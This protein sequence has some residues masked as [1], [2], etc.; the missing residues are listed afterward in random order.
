MGYPASIS[1]IIRVTRFSFFY[2]YPATGTWLF[3]VSGTKIIQTFVPVKNTFPMVLFLFK[4]LL[5]SSLAPLMSLT[6]APATGA[7]PPA[8]AQAKT[9]VI[10]ERHPFYISVTEINYNGKEKNLEISCKVF[11]EDIEQVL[12]K[13]Y[14]TELD[15]SKEA[16]KKSFDKYLP[17][18]ISRHLALTIDGKPVKLNYIGFEKEKESAF[19]YLEVP[20]A[21]P[22]KKIDIANTIL[23]DFTEDEINI[24]HVTINGKRQSTKL[25]YPERETSLVF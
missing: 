13:N 18:Y 1:G 20:A 19:C 22:P 15:I 5:A 23:Y 10:N 21:S 11:A 17:D 8:P 4:W 6:Q 16:D 14:K 2:C 24:I 7:A 9:V 25:D 12:E 3:N